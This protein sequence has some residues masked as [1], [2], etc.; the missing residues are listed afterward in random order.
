SGSLRSGSAGRYS[1]KR[2][3]NSRTPSRLWRR[4]RATNEQSPTLAC[5][6]RQELAFR[7]T[8]R[9]PAPALNSLSKDQ[10]MHPTTRLLATTLVALFAGCASAPAPKPATVP[11]QA[12]DV[13]WSRAVG[14]ATV[15]GRAEVPGP[16][17]AMHSCAG[18][19]AQLVPASPYAERMMA[20]LFG[21][22]RKG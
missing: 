20:T 17:R 1:R 2:A 3:A 21:N 15:E 6:Q 19:E 8:P 9:R 11:F 22:D 18:G 7:G 13:A 16:G 14:T 5:R 10:A 12:A 4:F